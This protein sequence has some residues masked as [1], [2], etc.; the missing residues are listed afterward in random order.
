MGA[1]GYLG[2]NSCWDITTLPPQQSTAASNP[3]VLQATRNACLPPE[4]VPNTPALPLLCGRDFKYPKLSFTSPTTSSSDTP[5]AALA[6]DAL[7]SWAP[8]SV[9]SCM[10]LL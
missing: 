9:W 3:L 2:V 6:L 10:L 8:W 7:S 4:Q 1:T 5:P